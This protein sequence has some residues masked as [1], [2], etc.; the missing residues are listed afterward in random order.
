[1]PIFILKSIYYHLITYLLTST[2]SFNAIVSSKLSE[3]VCD[4][5]MDIGD[6]ISDLN[7]EKKMSR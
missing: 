7:L 4:D 3:P 5:S 1:M 2:F 6:T